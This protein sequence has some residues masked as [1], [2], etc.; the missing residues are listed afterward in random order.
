LGFEPFKKELIALG[1]VT[2]VQ[3]QQVRNFVLGFTHPKPNKKTLR[4]I[5]DGRPLKEEQVEPPRASLTNLM[6]IQHVVE[7]YSYCIELD[8]VSYFNQFSMHE[9]ISADWV[10]KL[11]KERYAWQRMPMGW[12]R[13]VY[14][15]HSVAVLLAAM[16]TFRKESV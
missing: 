9:D 7:D 14:V 2:L 8:G 6:D 11:G 1:Y 15:A 4:G 13:A 5:L 10:L 12:G 16:C 3:R